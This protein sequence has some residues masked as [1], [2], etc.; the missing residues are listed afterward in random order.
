[1]KSLILTMSCT[2]A[3][4]IFTIPASADTMIC[5]SHIIK[6]GQRSGPTK[7]E[8][9]KK[10]GEPNEQGWDRWIYDKPG[11]PTYILKFNANGILNTIRRA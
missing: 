3:L 6:D 8:V 2:F 7:Y 9:L 4:S 10:C 5:G 11:Q 1:M